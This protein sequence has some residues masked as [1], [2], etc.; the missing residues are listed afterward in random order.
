MTTVILHP[1]DPVGF[2]ADAC[3]ALA[4]QVNRIHAIPSRPGPDPL[5]HTYAEL[6]IAYSH[7]T[8]PTISSTARTRIIAHLIDRIRESQAG[9]IT[10]PL[11]DIT[12][13]LHAEILS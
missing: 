11:V 3:A 10:V 6:V 1:H 5:A 12:D 9:D 2:V 13:R 7:L 4:A 8:L